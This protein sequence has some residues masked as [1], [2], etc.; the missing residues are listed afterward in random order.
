MNNKNKLENIFAENVFNLSVM[1]E[2][3]PKLIYKKMKKT[4]T[5]GATLPK[6]IADVVANV[7]KDWAI[8]KGATHYTHWFHPMTGK[9]AQKLDSF[10]EKGSD[11]GIIF[12]LSGKNLI[13]G[14][15]DASSFPSGGLRATF[16][17]RGYTAWDATS[18]AFIREE[19]NGKTLYIPTAF[20]S[21]TGEA[22]D[23]K[24]PLLRSMDVLS[25][26]AIRVLNLLGKTGVKRV[27]ANVGAEQEYFL[28]DKKYFD[29]RIDLLLTGRTLFGA[30]APK[31]QE[32]DDH[33]FGMIKERIARFMNNLDEQLWKLGVMAKTKH[34]EVAPAQHELAP[35]YE[36]ANVSTDQNHLIMDLIKKIAPKYDLEA[37][38]HEKPFANLNGSGKHNNWSLSTNSGENL[39]NPKDSPHENI[40]FLTF[41]V[42]IIVAIDRYPE[43]LRI[44]AAN[45]GNDHRLGANEAPPAI[46]SVFL[47]ERLTD[48][49]EQLENGKLT[50][51]KEAGEFKNTI[52]TLPDLNKD[53]TDR[54]R[55]SPFAFTGNKFEFR[56]VASSA[57]IA[58]ANIVLNTT[59]ASVLKE[60]ADELEKTNKTDEMILL[61]LQNLIKKHKRVIFNGNGYSDEWVKEAE[62]RGLPNLKTTVDAIPELLS[63]KSV[64]LFES[65]NVF[66]KNELTSRYHIML[67]TYSKKIDIE[68]KTML[69]ILSKEI[70]PDIMGTI[71][72][73]SDSVISVKRVSETI[74]TGYQENILKTIINNFNKIEK[75]KDNLSKERNIAKNIEDVL[76]LAIKYKEDILPAME[77]LRE[78][79]DELEIIMPSNDWPL[80][81]YTQLLFKI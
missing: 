15:P 27:I 32:L 59:V 39:L 49:L 10:I 22:L 46:I 67:E 24:T 80:P 5:E 75:L 64:N 72:N 21:Y 51:S 55:T 19:G 66:T 40:Q 43:L 35:I 41:L 53:A 9:T 54:N 7:M 57:S 26:Q 30:K 37:L 45:A 4:I 61:I 11:G 68:A 33:Y 16:E 63:D 74:D 20:Y 36:T 18:F 12:E 73:I 47:G 56:A 6:D 23:E 34:N 38:L 62:N 60:I 25:K 52:P 17:A 79:V 1:K 3:L 42:A 77:S 14:E 50:S 78:I 29:K 48:L 69:Y 13:Q 70:I 2:K 31:G 76:E 8:E 44:S 71:H 65:M 28:V 81:D 58:M